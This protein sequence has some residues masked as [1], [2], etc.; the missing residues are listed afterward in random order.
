[1]DKRTI[2][3]LSNRFGTLKEELATIKQDAG[4][5][6]CGFDEYPEALHFHHLDS[7]DK[8]FNISMSCVHGMDEVDIAE[9]IAKCIIVCANCHAGIHAKHIRL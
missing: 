6:I 4:C 2:A 3:K 8:K 7:E 1:M 9:E 5:A